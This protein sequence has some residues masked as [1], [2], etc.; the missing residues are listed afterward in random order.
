MQ[1]D[2]TT[3]AV[4]VT[5]KEQESPFTA[6]ALSFDDLENAIE[7]K[8]EEDT[9]EAQEEPE[10]TEEPAE[11]TPAEGDEK[12]SDD[13]EAEE[14][15]EKAEEPELCRY[16]NV[17]KIKAGDQEIPETAEFDVKVNGEATKATMR[18]LIDNYSGTKHVQQ[19]LQKLRDEQREFQGERA[20]LQDYING[21]HKS[22]LEDKDMG[23]FIGQVARALGADPVEANQLANEMLQAKFE[24]WNGL[25][26]N[27]RLLKSRDEELRLLKSMQQ[28]ERERRQLEADKVEMQARMDTVIKETGM[29][30]ETFVRLYEELTK[31]GMELGELT[32]ERVGEHFKQQGEQLAATEKS[33]S[34]KAML[35]EVNPKLGGEDLDSALKDL[36]DVIK[37]NPS[38]TDEDIKD[39]VQQAFGT[40]AAKNL[41]R[42]VKRNNQQRPQAEVTQTGSSAPLT[43][44][45]L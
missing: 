27:E 23:S 6:G 16:P 20:S 25:N 17:K 9:Q 10:K 3:D 31:S 43:F 15:E 4:N 41:S 38:M 26:E 30:E 24:E 11:P 34:L 18:Q 13:K 12:P 37:L 33:E 21:M 7:G 28:Q 22:L 29:D 35:T 36:E 14:G 39:V 8:S 44:D 40:R 1:T 45:E 5:P 42:K 19:E 32:P 2:D